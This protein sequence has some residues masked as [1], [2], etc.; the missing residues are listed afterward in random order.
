MNDSAIFKDSA[1]VTIWAELSSAKAQKTT[2]MS[3][4]R[5]QLSTGRI[6]I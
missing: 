1:R 6:I 3:N 2:P 4:G 5:V